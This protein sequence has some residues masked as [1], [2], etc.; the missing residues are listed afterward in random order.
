MAEVEHV[1]H[2]PEMNSTQHVLEDDREVDQVSTLTRVVN[3]KCLYCALL[4]GRTCQES[5]TKSVGTDHNIS[6]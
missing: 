5:N 1:E 2:V 3:G 6:Y 4:M